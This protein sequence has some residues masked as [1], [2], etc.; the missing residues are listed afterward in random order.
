MSAEIE[1]FITSLKREGC[2]KIA[3]IVKVAATYKM[4]ME[5]AKKAVH[6][7]AAWAAEK[8]GHEDFQRRLGDVTSDGTPTTPTP[9]S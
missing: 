5:A 3:S 6:E 4:G 2:S 9:D 7:S 1:E 8:P